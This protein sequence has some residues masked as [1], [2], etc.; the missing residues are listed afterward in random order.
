ML[1]TTSACV[2]LLLP[3]RPLPLPT[4]SADKAFSS[5]ATRFCPSRHAI[6]LPSLVAT[7]QEK[8]YFNPGDTGF[9]VFKTRFADIGVLICWDQ[10]GADAVV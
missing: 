10:V 2:C 1:Q 4:W 7:D 8:F 9:K 5:C 6:P 3:P